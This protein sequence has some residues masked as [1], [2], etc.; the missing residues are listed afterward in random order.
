MLKLFLIRHGETDWS[1]SGQHSG[2]ADLSLTQNGEDEARQLGERVQKIVFSHVLTSPLR[3]AK[4]TC[5]LAGLQTQATVDEDLSEWDNGDYEGKT[6]QEIL[7]KR[8][9]WNIFLD[10][11]PN[12]EMPTTISARADRLISKLVS[13]NGNVALFSHSHFG[14]VLAARWIGLSIEHGQRL[15]L[16][17]GSISVLTYEHDRTDQPAIALWN[18]LA[19]DAFGGTPR[20]ERAASNIRQSIERWENEGGEIPIKPSGQELRELLCV[21]LDELLFGGGAP[22]PDGNDYPVKQAGA[23]SILV[24]NPEETKRVIDTLLAD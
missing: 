9:G 3:R 20:E 19:L 18:S 10:G 17:T 15:L 23:V 2:R 8:G 14:R 11:C 12:G 5:N 22:F 24:N 4:Q 16:N 1:L 6:S 21:D 13:L 7:A